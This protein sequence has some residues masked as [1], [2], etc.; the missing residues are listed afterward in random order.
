MDFFYSC[1][2]KT[3]I[4]DYISYKQTWATACS[5]EITVSNCSIAGYL[6]PIMLISLH[7]I[8]DKL[9][10]VC[11]GSLENVLT[12]LKQLTQHAGAVSPRGQLSLGSL[13]VPG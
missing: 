11:F 7:F 9:F 5:D 1:L 13:A 12:V 6:I 3:C 4:C 8:V 2:H 10:G